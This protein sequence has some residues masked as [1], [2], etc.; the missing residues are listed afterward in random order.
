MCI[1]VNL[2][3]DALPRMWGT[4]S[5]ERF[6]SAQHWHTIHK[7]HVIAI[8]HYHR[9]RGSG[10]ETCIFTLKDC[11]RL[12]TLL[13]NICFVSDCW[14]HHQREN[15]DTPQVLNYTEWVDGRNHI[16]VERIQ[17]GTSEPLKGF[18]VKSC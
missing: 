8:A 18:V 5:F 17:C 16:Q 1:T 7:L 13:T 3:K 14:F 11:G 10:L 15:N 2:L 9:V 12:I 4:V 6:P